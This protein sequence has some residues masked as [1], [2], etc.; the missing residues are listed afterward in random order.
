MHRRTIIA[1]AAVSAF[2][3]AWLSAQWF[4]SLSPR[5][6]AM[7]RGAL[8]SQCRQVLLVRSPTEKSV[9]AQLWLLDRAH[10]GSWHVAAG[11]IPVTLGRKGLAW[12]VGE[13]CCEPP[14]GF[15]IKHEGDGCSPAGVFRIPFA[16]GIAPEAEAAWLK[17]RYVA[18]TPSIIGVDD[19]DSRYYNQV[20]DNQTNPRDWNSNEAMIRHDGLYRWGAF[21]AHNP[22]C[23]PR[24]G[25]CIFL[26]RWPAP[27]IP[28][29]GC[30]GM[31]AEDIKHILAWLDPA[32]E[33]RLVQALEKW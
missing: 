29:A 19:P 1:L 32:K 9:N 13:H 31:S 26:H 33:P 6:P 4:A 30:T 20:V 3:L 12:G 25:S 14:P 24:R 21:I 16:F 7:F 10:L 23:L 27:G 2:C 17:V 8:P 22:G 18:L 5:I 28:T 11:P 15:R